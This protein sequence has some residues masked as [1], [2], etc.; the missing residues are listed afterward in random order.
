LGYDARGN[1][2]A[3][4][5]STY[6]YNKLNQLTAGPG[7]TLYYD[8]S[9]RLV[10]YDTA[11]STRF[12]YAGS[13]MLAEVS[14]PSG[15]ILRRYVPGPGTDE[16]VV[17]Y[18]GST[19]ADRRWLHGDERGS[20]I[21]VSNGSGAMLAINR[22]D[23]YGIPQ[24]TNAGRFQY[25][26]QAWLPELGMYYYKARMYSPT[27]GR[28]MQT[29]PIGYG[30]GMNWYNYVGGDPVNF[31]DPSGLSGKRLWPD[32][33]SYCA[34]NAPGTPYVFAR[35]T[36]R[37]FDGTFDDVT[38][39]GGGGECPG[40]DADEIVVTGP[41]LGGGGGRPEQQSQWQGRP[42]YCFS[43]SYVVGKALQDFSAITSSVG[44]AATFLGAP[45]VGL[46][47]LAISGAMDVGGSLLKDSASGELG[48]GTTLKIGQSA[49]VSR[50][51]IAR[52]VR[53]EAAV[54]N[55]GLGKVQDKAVA[56]EDRCE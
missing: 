3:S 17:W 28:F 49:L 27:L 8:T 15:T 19:T 24:S 55:E 25:T 39:T 46:P 16:P 5:S 53:N 6:S 2:T 22:Y 50:I 36:G 12:Y 26:G 1:L 13:A 18:E 48:M 56:G 41:L 33:A 42:D 52:A 9:G 10:E 31:A 34:A 35:G 40:I 21:A 7:V 29:D 47:L 43:R 30:D 20:V 4:G 51:P 54:V 44:I 23:E 11:T 14:N 45:E 32:A 38:P 37:Q